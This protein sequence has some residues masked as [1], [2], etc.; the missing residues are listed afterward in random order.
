[1]SSRWYVSNKSHRQICCKILC[2][3]AALG[4]GHYGMH[5][6]PQGDQPC[7]CIN[8]LWKVTCREAQVLVTLA[9]NYLVHVFSSPLLCKCILF[10]SRISNPISG[11]ASVTNMCTLLFTFSHFIQGSHF[12]SCF[13]VFPLC[14]ISSTVV[15]ADIC[16]LNIFHAF[17]L[18]PFFIKK[19]ALVLVNAFFMSL[20]FTPPR[21]YIY[22]CI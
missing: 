19:F 22:K 17:T 6:S 8:A 4:S 2:M 9:H 13:H 20:L 3:P 16:K 14:S 21:F 18:T 10:C 11:C 12:M 5:E 15:L 7:R 1:M